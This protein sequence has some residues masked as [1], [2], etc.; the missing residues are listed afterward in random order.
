MHGSSWERLLVQ[1][2]FCAIFWTKQPLTSRNAQFSPESHCW[3]RLRKYGEEGEPSF[4][5]V[6]NVSLVKAEIEPRLARLAD[7]KLKESKS[8]KCMA[9]LS[10]IRS[11]K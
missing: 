3:A 1:G 9:T 7:G 11:D 6:R 2:Q 4:S 8:M 10:D 5:I